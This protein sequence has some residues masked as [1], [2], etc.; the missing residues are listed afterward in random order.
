MR[1]PTNR[2]YPYPIYSQFSDDYVNNQFFVERE[3]EYDSENATITFD[4]KIDNEDIIELI[5]KGDVGIFCQIDCSST[6]YREIF[7]I[8]YSLEKVSKDIPLYKLNREVE[9]ICLL[10]TKKHISDFSPN[11]VNDLYQDQSIE[12]PEF[13]VIGY[14]NTDEIL[15][16]KK[17]DV[18]GE[19]PSIFTIT[20]SEEYEDVVYDTS[21]EQITIFLPKHQYE[22]YESYRGSGVRIK[23]M[24]IIVPVL[25]SII[26][27]IQSGEEGLDNKGWYSALE[28][29]LVNLGYS[30]GFEDSKFLQEDTFELS[31]KI[32]KHVSLDAFNEF[33]KLNANDQEA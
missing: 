31:Q 30:S 20:M 29:A 16:T 17:I 10:V 23:Q 25:S 4:T 8:P 21:D 28:N 33:D 1:I 18:N 5:N 24:M 12:I 11:T 6:K 15:F 27:S 13:V 9:I 2:L 26:K 14:T 7:E 3:V 19:I 22:I 32:L